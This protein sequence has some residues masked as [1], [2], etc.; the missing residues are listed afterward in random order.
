M[1]KLV[2][3]ERSNSVEICRAS[4]RAC[5]SPTITMT[6]GATETRQTKIKLV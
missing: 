4:V 3:D 2:N 6:D 1:K 5:T